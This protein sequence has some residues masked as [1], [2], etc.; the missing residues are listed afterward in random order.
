MIPVHL[1]AQADRLVELARSEIPH[2]DQTSAPA[3]ARM[4]A[5]VIQFLND[6]EPGNELAIRLRI[7][8]FGQLVKHS[9]ENPCSDHWSLD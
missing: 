3:V 5:E 1:Q 8:A 7:M 4:A 6:A 9:R 2:I